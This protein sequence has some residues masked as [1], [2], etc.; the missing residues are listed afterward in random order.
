MNILVL[1]GSSFIGYHLIQAL[2]QSGIQPFVADI[3]PPLAGDVRYKR[4]D[5]NTLSRDDP[6][7]KGID[8][9]YDL[10]WTTL[11]KTSNEDPARDVN[12]NLSITLNILRGC[13]NFGVKKVVFISSGGT[14]YGISDGIPSQERDPANP[15]C[16]YGIT[17]LMVE[18]YLNLYRHIYGLDY[19]VLRPSNAY[20]EFQNPVGNQGA[21]AVFLAH[22]LKGMPI[23][24]WG[25][26]SAVRDYLYAGDLADAMIKVL[27]YNP[28]SSE[29]RIFNVGSGKGVSLNELLHIISRVTGLK[30]TVEYKEARTLDV[31]CNILDIS[32]IKEKMGWLPKWNI[33]SG[34]EKTWKWMKDYLK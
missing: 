19:I 12:S 32:L 27:D 28:S 23:T 25:D 7:F 3:N 17:K 13:V 5:L 29:E 34:I 8:V 6:I 9:I 20:G 1:G 22:L 24:I 2:K 33:T 18:K 31:P 10:A 30:P 16:S 11:P 14:V 15:I 21:I 26:G 4:V